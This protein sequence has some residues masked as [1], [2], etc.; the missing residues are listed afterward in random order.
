MSKI[1][2]YKSQMFA[3]TIVEK[4]GVRSFA[5][6][7]ERRYRHFLLTICKPGDEVSMYMTNKRPKRSNQQN[8]YYHLYL[9][10]IALSTG[11]DEEDLHTWAKGE[12]LSKGITEV[13]GRKVR[14]VKSTTELTIGEFLEFLQRIE[15]RTG[16]PLPDTEPF[17]TPLSHSEYQELTAKQKEIYSKIK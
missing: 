16:I 1:P 9:S 15:E 4:Y 2:T 3:G 11:N 10:L 8:N 13:F 6:N 12:F 17:S 14:K 7:D 5:M